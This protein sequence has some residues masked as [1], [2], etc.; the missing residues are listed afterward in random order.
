MHYDVH[1]QISPKAGEQ[2]L[3]K[4][5]TEM[6]D[7]RVGGHMEIF[8]ENRLRSGAIYNPEQTKLQYRLNL[9]DAT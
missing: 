7:R 1:L 3:R 9:E 6:D 8:G 2:R 4:N 5:V